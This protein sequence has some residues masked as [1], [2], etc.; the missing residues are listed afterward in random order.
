MDA[1]VTIKRG[2][3]SPA[4]RERLV[5]ADGTAPSLTGATVEFHMTHALT[6]VVVVNT[7]SHVTVEQNAAPDTIVSYAWQTA[8]VADEGTYLYEWE[9][10][11]S[12]GSIETF[13]NTRHKVLK[14]ASDLA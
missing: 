1:D 14:I 6:G 10:T 13:P 8:D 12:D 9:V 11:Y 4:I 7:A 2:D 5:G 3:T